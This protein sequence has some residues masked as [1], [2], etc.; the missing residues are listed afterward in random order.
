MR[1]RDYSTGRKRCADSDQKIVNFHP[2]AAP[3]FA[4]LVAHPPEGLDKSQRS[5]LGRVRKKLKTV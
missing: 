2:R 4:E 3:R 1:E 5:A